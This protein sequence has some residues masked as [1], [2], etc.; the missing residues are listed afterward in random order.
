MGGPDTADLR[1]MVF[2]LAIAGWTVERASLYDEE[3][4]KGWRWIEPKHG[5]AY[6][7]I[8]QWHE[9]PAWPA[10]A[11]TETLIRDYGYRP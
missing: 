2:A 7:A 8:G 4:V 5:S 3:D 10:R 11:A 6:C 9:L 1:A